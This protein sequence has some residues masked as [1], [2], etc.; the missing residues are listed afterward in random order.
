MK[1]SDPSD[2]IRASLAI[3][4]AIRSGELTL[5]VP[6]TQCLDTD[7]DAIEDNPKALNYI[8]HS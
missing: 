1:P 4:D 8:I 2:M 7:L 5:E 3:D 6:Q